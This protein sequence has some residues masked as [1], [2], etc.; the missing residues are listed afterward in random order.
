MMNIGVA[1]S[2][3]LTGFSRFYAN[4]EAKKLLNSIKFNFDVH[5][6]VSFL[7]NGEK[8]YAIFFSKDVV[9]VSLIT[10]ILDS[11]RRPGNLV[12]T[13][14]IPRGYKIV[15]GLSLSGANALYNLLNELNDKFYE[16]NFLNGMINQ[17]PAVLMQDYYTEILSKFRLEPDRSQRKINELIDVTAPNKNTGYV[18]ALE[19]N[20][21]PY[22]SSLFRKSYEGYHHIFFASNAPQNID[23]PAEEIITYKVRVSNDNRQ[24]H[25]E[26][27]LDD[28]IPTVLPQLGEIP[29]PNQNYTYRQ[30]LNGDAGDEII[31]SIEN[32]TIVLTYRFQQEEKTVYFK[33]Y[34]GANE[35]PLHVLRPLIED[36][37]GSSYP[38]SAESWTFRGEKIYGLK[39]IKSG[40]PE[41]TIEPHSIRLDL[42]PLR[43]GATHNV[44]VSKGWTWTFDP[45]I[46]N[47]RVNIKPISITLVNK[48]TREKKDIAYVT[49]YVSERLSGSAQEWEMHIESDYYK[50]ATFP[51]TG[52]YRLEPKPQT[53]P[54][55]QNSTNG[56]HGTNVQHGGSG[57]RTHGNSGQQ[58]KLSGGEN[59]SAKE[60][61]R[62]EAEK[63]KRLIQYGIYAA[64]AIICCVGGW[65]GYTKLFPSQPD[66]PTPDN[67]IIATETSVTKNVSFRFKD[68]DGDNLSDATLQKLSVSVEPSSI[69]SKTDDGYVIRYDTSS[70]PPQKVKVNVSFQNINMLMKDF[71]NI[72]EIQSLD[73]IVDIPL[74]VKES[75]INMFDLLEVGIN[76]KDYD[77]Y[78][79]KINGRGGIVDRNYDYGILLNQKLGNKPEVKEVKEEKK[80]K[81]EKKDTK[82][83]NNTKSDVPTDLDEIWLTVDHLKGKTGEQYKSPAAQARITT[84]RAILVGFGQSKVPSSDKN[85]STEQARI[86]RELIAI[87]QK[88]DAVNNPDLSEKFN[89]QLA[90]KKSL[91][92]VEDITRTGSYF[93]NQLK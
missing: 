60:Q 82:V 53:T 44:Y 69:V 87:K 75:E 6:L 74:S 41:Y 55:N 65:W 85:L 24:I 19:R 37:N 13:V 90:K 29:I 21:P 34:D 50:S 28:R 58:I 7:N 73:N 68:Y 64:V 2:G 1:I 49:G 15:N 30:V 11:F 9:A 20:I 38:L 36:S 52:P 10:N 16:R 92:Q 79:N 51:A 23:E 91:K 78:H 93:N 22:L 83:V 43:E 84:L 88:I 47:R 63:K 76:A 54:V 77:G 45:M 89:K 39:T 48:Y 67:P 3:N 17:N 59:E 4:D 25:G 12:V 5:N 72:F 27:R 33:F 61:T 86:V 80:I 81:E 32:G 62:I 57:T 18:S 70:N 56:G 71:Q 46:N 35:V 14:L 42:Q 31:G 40:N 66:E 8:L 26:V